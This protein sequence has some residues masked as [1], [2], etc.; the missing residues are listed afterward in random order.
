MK[1][2]QTSHPNPDH[3]T[4]SIEALEQQL[5]E[6]EFEH[7]RKQHTDSSYHSNGGWHRAQAKILE[8]QNRIEAAKDEENA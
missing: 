2:A 8:L 3:P 5:S 6:M 7:L 4:Q 1:T